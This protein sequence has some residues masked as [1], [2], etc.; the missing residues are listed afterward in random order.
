MEAMNSLGPETELSAEQV[1]K[2]D[3][4]FPIYEKPESETAAIKRDFRRIAANL[5]GK[6][7]GLQTGHAKRSIA[8]ALTL[9]ETASMFVVKAVHQG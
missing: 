7:S 9:L 2:L 1:E 8:E 5:L 3:A 4:M 6:Q